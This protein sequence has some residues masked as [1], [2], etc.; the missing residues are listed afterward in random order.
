[1]MMTN[2]NDDADDD[3]NFFDIF[4]FYDNKSCID[5]NS[6][7][8][9]RVFLVVNKE[10]YND[11]SNE[12]STVLWINQQMCNVRCL[13]QSHYDDSDVDDKRERYFIVLNK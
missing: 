6:F 12:C 3:D 13:H 10:M 1:M 5:W 2:A 4:T 9:C 11:Q 7:R 8:R